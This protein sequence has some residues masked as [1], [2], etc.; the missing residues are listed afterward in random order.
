[1]SLEGR[2]VRQKLTYFGHVMRT[3]SLK[4]AM[5]L[6]MV[7]GKRGRGKPKTRWLDTIKTDTEMTIQQL[8]EAVI[9][10][11]IWHNIV[12]RVSKGRKRLNG[13]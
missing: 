3:N 4:K 7:S 2:I 13:K 11:V 9:N 8:K 12:H 6:G 10:R 1:M 5:M